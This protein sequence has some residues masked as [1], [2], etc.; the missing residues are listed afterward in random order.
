[1]ELTNTIWQQLDGG[2]RTPYDVSIP[3]KKFEKSGDPELINKIWKEL[4]EELHHQGDVGLASY[5]ALPQIVRICISKKIFDINLLGLCSIIEQQRYSENNPNLPEEFSNYY[6]DGLKSF[7]H[8]IIENLNNSI[9]DST[10]ILALSSL[11]VC[12]GNIKIGKALMLLEE[13]SIM[14]EFLEQH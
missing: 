1:M 10:F 13:K 8:F 9:E 2:Y 11:A 14:D 5:L 12:N 7:K 4:W 3:L 6:F